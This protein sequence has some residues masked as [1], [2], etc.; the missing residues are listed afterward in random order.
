MNGGCE[1]VR[2]RTPERTTQ[3]P[4]PPRLSTKPCQHPESPSS[5]RM[6]FKNMNRRPQVNAQRT[7]ALLL[8][9]S[10]SVG[11]VQCAVAAPNASY[12]LF[13]PQPLGQSAPYSALQPHDLTQGQMTFQLRLLRLHGMVE[14]IPGTHQ[15]RL[16]VFGLRTGGSLPSPLHASCALGSP[17]L[18]ATSLHDHGGGPCQTARS[19]QENHCCGCSVKCAKVAAH[20]RQ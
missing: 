9:R 16:T 15:Y 7:S 8:R 19:R 4:S 1:K 13:Q 6:P 5:A 10:A 3:T 20:L 12:R 18:L 2:N 17:A 11:V 14:H